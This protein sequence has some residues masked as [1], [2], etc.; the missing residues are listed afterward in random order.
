MTNSKMWR[1]RDIVPSIPYSDV[2]RAAEGLHASSV[3][4]SALCRHRTFV[5]DQP[6]PTRAAE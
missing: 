4:T 6:S 1:A 2:P 3:C 5:S